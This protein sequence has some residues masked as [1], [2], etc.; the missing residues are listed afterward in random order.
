MY[1]RNAKIG[2]KTACQ[3]AVQL[4]VKVQGSLTDFYARHNTAIRH[5]SAQGC[6][7]FKITKLKANI[8]PLIAKKRHFG[9]DFDGT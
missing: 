9:T 7:F 2:I 3:I 8:Y 1:S 6:A 5:G 4:V